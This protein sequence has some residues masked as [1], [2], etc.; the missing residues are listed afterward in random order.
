VDYHRCFHSR[1]IYYS[2]NGIQKRYVTTLYHFQ[3]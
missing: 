3:I 2:F 1:W